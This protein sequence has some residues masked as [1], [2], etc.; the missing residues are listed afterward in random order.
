M[1]L[2]CALTLTAIG[3]TICCHSTSARCEMGPSSRLGPIQWRTIC[4]RIVARRRKE[5]RTYPAE[6]DCLRCSLHASV[7]RRR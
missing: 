6:G 1:R 4:R 7:G 3:T 2:T 5:L